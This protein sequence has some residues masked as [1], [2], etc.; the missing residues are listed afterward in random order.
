MAVPYTD[1]E[2]DEI[3]NEG[4]DEGK[5]EGVTEGHAAGYAEALDDMKAALDKLG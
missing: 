1:D 3:R 5:A 4:F 2:L